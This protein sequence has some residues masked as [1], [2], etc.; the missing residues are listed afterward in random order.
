MLLSIVVLSRSVMVASSIWVYCPDIAWASTQYSR[1]VIP[2]SAK[3]AVIR[4]ASTCEACASRKL[5]STTCRPWTGDAATF[6]ASIVRLLVDDPRY[7]W[8]DDARA[9]ISSAVEVL[10][11]CHDP[12]IVLL[13]AGWQVEFHEDRGDVFFDR[14]ERDHERRGDGGVGAPF[15]HETEYLALFAG[16]PG[17]RVGVPAAGQ[18]LPDD[19]GVQGGSARGHATGRFDEL[20]NVGDAVFEQVA[21]RPGVA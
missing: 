13:V 17:E 4:V 5:M 21:D 16:Q 9:P 12:P 18:E 1:G 3:A 8:P 15:G 7:P 14:S 2:I 11:D 20:V 6:T 10:D 19:F